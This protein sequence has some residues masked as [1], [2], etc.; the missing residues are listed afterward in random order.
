MSWFPI[1]SLSPTGCRL[2]GQTETIMNGS[3][4]YAGPSGTF[5]LFKRETFKPNYAA[6]VSS[7]SSFFTGRVHGTRFNR[8]TVSGGWNDSFTEQD[9]H[10]F[11]DA[12]NGHGALIYNAFHYHDFERLI[13][14]RGYNGI[15]MRGSRSFCRQIGGIACTS[16][17][18]YVSNALNS[19]LRVICANNNQYGVFVNAAYATRVRLG[20]VC[21]NLYGTS[22]NT[23]TVVEGMPGL[24]ANNGSYLYTAPLAGVRDFVL[25]ANG[26]QPLYPINYARRCSFPEGLGTLPADG[27]DH[28]I[29]SIDHN[30]IN[31]WHLKT[32]D[33]AKAETMQGVSRSG[34]PWSWRLYV[35]S[36]TRD[37]NYPL[38][39]RVG[40]LAYKQGQSIMASVWVKRS[41]TALSIRFGAFGGQMQG[42]AED[43]F[44]PLLNGTDWEQLTF[45]FLPTE[46]G[47]GELY[48]LAFGGT[49]HWADV[50]DLEV[51]GAIGVEDLRSMAIIAEDFAATPMVP[52]A[53]SPQ[54]IVIDD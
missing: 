30:A 1:A 37:D 32:F 11:I 16:Y 39:F 34:A 42:L 53:S 26:S 15:D 36:S 29:V 18:V 3:K 14:V 51:K 43:S 19:D 7:T 33:G 47:T 5:P 38:R 46:S 12:T 45:S 8:V 10:T 22:I 41:S 35:T 6:V 17:G 25:Y 13:G 27:N 9:G 52:S 23:A 4:G 21:N 31:G 20:Y 2:D 50:D 40:R 54:V 48:L 49:T 24:F 28:G 44:V